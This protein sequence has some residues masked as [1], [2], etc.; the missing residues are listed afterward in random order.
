MI[1]QNASFPLLFLILSVICLALGSVLAK[2]I[3]NE[4]SPSPFL[5]LVVQLIGSTIFLWTVIAVQGIRFDYAKYISLLYKVGLVVGVGSIF[6]ILALNFTSAS[7][8]SIVFAIQPVL[9]VVFAWGLLQ[10]RPQGYHL[11]FGALA[12]V[13]VV[14]TIAAPDANQSATNAAGA[15]FALISTSLAALYVVMM[16]RI[17]MTLNPLVALACIQTMGLGIAIL[18]WVIGGQLLPLSN[19]PITMLQGVGIA[20]TGA[21]YYGLAFWLYLLGLQTITASVAGLYLNL[22]PVFTILF[23]FFLIGERLTARG[24]LG[25]LTVLVAIFCV[26]LF[27]L[28]EDA[29]RPSK[30]LPADASCS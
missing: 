26:S 4:A 21:I 22:V 23:A 18:T 19:D 15:V 7:L 1:K 2:N 17:T 3:L 25:V 12:V 30:E 11:L 5:F 24:W 10:E 28:R 9:I 16:R 8:A 6:T 27:T 14:I 20:A 13:G 29:S